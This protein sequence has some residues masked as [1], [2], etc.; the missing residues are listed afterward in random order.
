MQKILFLCLIAVIA[1][2]QMQFRHGH[3]GLSDDSRVKAEIA[4]Q[5]RINADLKDRNAMME[6]KIA[7]LKGSADSIEARSRNELNL[8]KAG[9]V[10]VL[11]PGSDIEKPMK[12]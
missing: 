6:M 2:F 7:G 10:L 11:L 3:G 5:K 4:E 8:V 9:E 1:L 12:K